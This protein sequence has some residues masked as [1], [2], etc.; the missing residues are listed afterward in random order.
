[1]RV[2]P[3]LYEFEDWHACFA[4]GFETA[5][6][7]QL[8]LERGKET[9]AHGI[10]EA[11]ADG[12]HRGSYAGFAAALA[13]GDR[14]V[15]GEFKRSSHHL[16]KGKCDG[17]SKAPFRSVRASAVAFAGPASGRE[18][19]AVLG[20]YCSGP[21]NRGRCSRRRRVARRGWPVVP[22]GGRRDTSPLF[23]IFK[24]SSGRYLSFA[25]REEFAILRVQEH[26]V[27]AI[28]RKLGRTPSTIS[29][30]LRRNTATRDGGK[31]ET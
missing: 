14:S 7:E 28:A 22:E 15:L 21:F 1:M 17:Y 13:E 25:E 3:S 19:S 16:K 5:S 11:I 27:R 18:L 24:A 30:E 6:V 23:T 9:L 29:R 20:V 2:V 8:T 31:K 10:I 4:L 26:G 12:A